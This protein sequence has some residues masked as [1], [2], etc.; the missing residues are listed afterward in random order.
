MDASIKNILVPI[1][2]SKASAKAVEAAIS[3]CKQHD[4]G[5]HLL[6]V[7]DWKYN[8]TADGFLP[9]Y[10]M[11]AG[12][13][14]ER[15][16]D[17]ELLNSFIQRFFHV[18]CSCALQEGSIPQ[19][20]AGYAEAHSCDLIVLGIDPKRNKILFLNDSIPF[21]LLEQTPC[22]VLT[23]PVNRKSKSF[24]RILFPVRQVR[25]NIEKFNLTDKLTGYGKNYFHLLGILEHG[26]EEDF[27]MLKKTL[28]YLKRRIHDEQIR[29]SQAIHFYPDSAHRVIQAAKQVSPDLIVI[30][31]SARRNFWQFLFGN[32]TQR[33][34]NNT[35]AAVL[36]VK[37]KD[38]TALGQMRL[39]LT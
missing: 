26:K 4:A 24:K 2:F 16:G 3:L 19:T 34:I 12:Q 22:P 36:C 9:V 7:D 1:N 30:T 20:I 21:S 29:F 31:A 33:V 32:Y 28:S 5:L 37:E 38:E 13:K 8:F 25:N 11:A 18:D 35:Q 15:T 39:V 10:A 27:S 17:L 14:R 6:H 23:V